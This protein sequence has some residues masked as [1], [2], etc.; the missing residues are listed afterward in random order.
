MSGHLPPSAKSLE[1]FLFGLDKGISSTQMKRLSNSSSV[2]A[3]ISLAEITRSL[4]LL[5]LDMILVYEFY[6]YFTIQLISKKKHKLSSPIN[7]GCTVTTMHN[8]TAPVDKRGRR[9][10]NIIPAK[11][12]RWRHHFPW[13]ILTLNRPLRHLIF[14]QKKIGIAMLGIFSLHILLFFIIFST[15]CGQS[16]IIQT[17]VK[18]LISP[19]LL[20]LR[21]VTKPLNSITRVFDLD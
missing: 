6:M 1:R 12:S 19:I 9:Y 8:R 4:C 21:A 13:T 14:F 7:C 5:N 15:T 16:L 2:T 17:P 11:Y 20:Q 3:L 10:R 18:T